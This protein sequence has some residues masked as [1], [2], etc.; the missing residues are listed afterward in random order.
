MNKSFLRR[1]GKWIISAGMGII[2]LSLMLFFYQSNLETA[3]SLPAGENGTCFEIRFS[4]DGKSLLGVKNNRLELFDLETKQLKWRIDKRFQP[5]I[6]WL[7]DERVVANPWEGGL[8]LSVYSRADG[9]LLESVRI[10]E[11]FKD[12]CICG[13]IVLGTS[14]D[15]LYDFVGPGQP[16]VLRGRDLRQFALVNAAGKLT[17]LLY[18]HDSSGQSVSACQIRT[19][20]YRVAVTHSMNC[21]AKICS[22]TMNEHSEIEERCPPSITAELIQEI[23]VP[24]GSRVALSTDGTF[25]VILNEQGMTR[26]DW[27]KNAY[28]QVAQFELSVDVNVSGKCLAIS[29]DDRWIAFCTGTEVIVLQSADLQIQSRFSSPSYAL[30]FSPDSSLLAVAQH[31]RVDAYL[32]QP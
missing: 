15:A 9:S 1:N 3:W 16:F 2:F 22:L 20:Q 21:P 18:C 10:G 27:Q 5:C 17:D 28:Q 13:Q 30:C 29:P 31:M 24:N 25:L 19:G 26:Y 11:D 23:A 4:P 6:T 12:L 7:D 32:I 14:G 8:G